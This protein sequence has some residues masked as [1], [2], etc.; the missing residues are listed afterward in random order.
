[1]NEQPGLTTLHTL[2]HRY[3]N[4]LC[5]TLK[6]VNPHWGDERLYREARKIVGALLQHITF[7]EWLP[8]LLGR[9]FMEN[10]QLGVSGPDFNPYQAHN[11]AYDSQM[12]P[13]IMNSFATAAMR[14]GHSLI[15]PR[16]RT[17]YKR[18]RLR[19]LF[20]RPK[21]ALANNGDGVDVIASGLVDLPCQTP[22]H[23]FVTEITDH[24][25]EDNTTK[26]LDLT[27]LNI[28]RGRDH[29][30]PPYND[31]RRACGLPAIEDYRTLKINF[32][33][34]YRLLSRAYR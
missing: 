30:L 7:Y 32:P 12:N 8:I 14:F 24:L 5:M 16:F 18:E 29:G 10:Y 11:W 20:N 15:P 4:R 1:V 3:H 13:D 22:D 27:S 21:F 25:F 17:S 6:S 34:R 2:F 9:V 19:N 26:S 33:S 28:Q 31:F 23:F